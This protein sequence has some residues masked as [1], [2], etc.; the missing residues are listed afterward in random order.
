MFKETITYTD[1]NGVER[2]EDFYFNLSKGEIAKMQLAHSGNL[3]DWMQSVIEAK[4]QQKIVD[5]FNEI[6]DMSYGI[7]SEDGRRFI[8]TP[9]VLEE[10]KQTEAYSDFYF[11][12]V[13]DAA[14]ASKFV[15]A[16]IPADIQAQAASQSPKLAS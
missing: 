8:K 11:K 1:Y 12:L 7:K 16:I 10:F 9:Q 13:T 14:Y 2:T 15:N 3:A 4:D 6:V 5:L